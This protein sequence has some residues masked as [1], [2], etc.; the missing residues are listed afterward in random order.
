MASAP[1]E[2][3][4][5]KLTLWQRLAIRKL[6]K[7][8]RRG[9]GEPL[10]PED[11]VVAWRL[12][13]HGTGRAVAAL[14][15]A[16]PR[17]PRCA[18]CGAPFAGVGARIVGPLGYRPSR[19]NPTICDVCVEYAPPG[20]MVMYAGILFA[21][22]RGFTERFVG[23]DPSA[24]PPVLRQFYRCAEDVLFPEAVIDKLIGDE[25][26]ALYLP[27]LRRDMTRDDVSALMLEHAR[28]LLRSVGY[29][30]ESGPFVELG[31]GMDAG[32]AF[33]GNI[34]QR[35]LYDF[36]AV[37]DVVNTA[38]RLQ[39]EAAAGEIVMSQRVASGL[40]EPVGD[41]AELQL[42]GKTEPEVVY[43]IAV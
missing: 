33:V 10:E 8:A 16:L 12:H 40:P 38:S 28:Q 27:D 17:S 24:V 25:V 2:Q 31:I 14:L 41:R 43:R 26:M 29:G 3:A 19:K 36:T 5:T 20:G 18:V 39:S 13:E 7:A 21:D 1:P 37:G 32:E 42:K 34:G 35:A 11:W 9:D 23:L 22:L 6:R 4:P 30:T 15:N